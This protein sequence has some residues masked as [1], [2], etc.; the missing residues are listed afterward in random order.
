MIKVAT[1][2]PFQLLLEEVNN[3]NALISDNKRFARSKGDK[4]GCAAR[5]AKIGRKSESSF[6]LAA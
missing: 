1:L 6:S 2:K 5:F 4:V 3:I